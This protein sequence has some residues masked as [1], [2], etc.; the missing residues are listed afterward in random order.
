[1]KNPKKAWKGKRLLR[2]R[3]KRLLKGLP[4][5]MLNSLLR[6]FASKRLDD[7]NLTRVILGLGN[8]G[9]RYQATRH[10]F[11]VMVLGD[12]LRRRHLTFLPGRGSFEGSR[13]SS[14]GGDVLLVRPTTFMNH[15]GRAALE[16]RDRTGI[17]ADR[18]LVLCDDLDLPLGRIRL[19]Q[20]GGSGGHR[21]LESLI[22]ELQSEDFLRLRIG[23]GRPPE[24]VEVSDYVLSAFDGEELDRGRRIV[25]SAADAVEMFLA[26]GL[27]K[28]AMRFNPLMIES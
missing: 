21:G 23:I 4:K 6:F 3:A 22:R 8:P 12:L 26:E 7:Q 5:K 9:R 19:K 13:V 28:T 1:M 2:V 11:G 17:S 18:F 24:G 25:E 10:N 14:P 20:G 15:S 27:E 16:I